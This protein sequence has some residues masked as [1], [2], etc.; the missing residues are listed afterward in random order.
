MLH[1]GRPCVTELR[2]SRA[3]ISQE[4]GH[5]QSVEEA[6]RGRRVCP[7]PACAGSCDLLAEAPMKP[8]GCFHVAARACPRNKL[9]PRSTHRGSVKDPLCVVGS[10]ARCGT[11]AGRQPPVI[12]QAAR[13][14]DG[15]EVL[16]RRRGCCSPQLAAQRL[17]GSPMLRSEGV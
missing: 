16:G 7:V 5:F 13:R 2:C 10:T 14:C 12:E 17:T 9:E 1:G 8:S 3:V 6:G 15:R 4:Y 11:R